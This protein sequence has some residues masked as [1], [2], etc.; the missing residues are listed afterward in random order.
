MEF[1]RAGEGEGAGFGDVAGYGGAFAGV[2]MECAA[3][4]ESVLV[5]DAEVG[6]VWFGDGRMALFF[7]EAKHLMRGLWNHY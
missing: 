4:W 2:D 3:G 6:P 7:S 5:E 1:P